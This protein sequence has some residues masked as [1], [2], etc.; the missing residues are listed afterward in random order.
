MRAE[1][2]A[3][4]SWFN[5]LD[6]VRAHLLVLAAAAVCL[7]VLSYA[8]GWPQSLRPAE[9]ETQAA[10]VLAQGAGVPSTR[11]SLPVLPA[12]APRDMESLV[13][14]IQRQLI[15]VGCYHGEVSGKWSTPSRLAMQA[16][17]EQVNARLPVDRPDQILLRL[18]E[19]HQGRACGARPPLSL[20]REGRLPGQSGPAQSGPAQ[21]GKAD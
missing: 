17:T 16:F 20:V 21:S 14:E 13:R 9:L 2:A 18:I 3:A 15:R 5:A 6:R 10:I 8:T 11:A 1:L 12:P 7:C 4:V 19:G